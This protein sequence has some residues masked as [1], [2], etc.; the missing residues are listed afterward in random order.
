MAL[1]SRDAGTVSVGGCY[2]IT[3]RLQQ[4][5]RPYQPKHSPSIHFSEYEYMNN[6]QYKYY[7]H[8]FA[9]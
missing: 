3:R 7:A 2:T 6:V 4:Y 5:G 9:L 1:H 8:V